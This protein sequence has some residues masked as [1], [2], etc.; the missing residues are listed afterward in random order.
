[1]LFYFSRIDASE[2][3]GSLGRL[4]NDDE[5]DS[6]SVVKRV[7]VDGKPRLCFFASKNIGK[8]EEVT[9]TY[10]QGEYDQFPWREKVSVIDILIVLLAEK[11]K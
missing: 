9:F 6:N 1:M 8:G 11:F 3:D 4:V 5:K 7:I 2:E 10:F